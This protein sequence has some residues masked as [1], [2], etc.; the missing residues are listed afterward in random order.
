[1]STNNHWSQLREKVQVMGVNG[2]VSIPILF[3]FMRPMSLY[4]FGFFLFVLG[5][6]LY[7]EK[8]KK[9]DLMYVPFAMRFQ[10]VGGRKVPRTS[11]FDI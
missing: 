4:T 2:I 5:F 10:I 11:G 7:V 1:M 3:W 9:L 6:V 8:Y